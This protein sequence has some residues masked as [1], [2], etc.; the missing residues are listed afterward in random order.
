MEISF[1]R[2]YPKRGGGLPH[3]SKYSFYK[4][5]KQIVVLIE[6]RLDSG[7]KTGVEE[8]ETS[9]EEVEV[10]VEEEV[11]A[12]VNVAAGVEGVGGGA[13]EYAKYST[14]LVLNSE[15]L[16]LTVA[17]SIPENCGVTLQIDPQYR[18]FRG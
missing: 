4:K 11:G 5:M 14:R 13:T 3:S 9:V 2:E 15:G 17:H 18:V 16:I 6:P 12:K 1:E 10:G 8:V 7:V